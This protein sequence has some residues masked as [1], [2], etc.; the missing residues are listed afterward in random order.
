LGSQDVGK[1]TLPSCSCAIPAEA[2]RNARIA[3][4]TNS[5]ADFIVASLLLFNLTAYISILDFRFWILDC[6][7][8]GL[9]CSLAPV[10]LVGSP[11]DFIFWICDF[12]F[13][14]EPG[15]ETYE[16]IPSKFFRTIQNPKSKIQNQVIASLLTLT[17]YRNTLSAL[18]KTFGGIVT[19]ICFAVFRLI[20]NSNL[21]G[22]STGM[23]AGFVPF[24]TLSIR[25]AARRCASG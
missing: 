15:Q 2:K 18:A 12:G 1:V 23:S 25:A 14:I 16:M 24:K 4:N 17:P 9:P 11:P 20:T 5:F 10:H 3:N 19:P 8:I 7:I 22:C 21:I 13:W 6:P